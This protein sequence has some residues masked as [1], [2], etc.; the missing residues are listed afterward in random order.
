MVPPIIV[1]RADHLSLGHLA[2]ADH[3]SRVK[4]LRVHM[5]VTKADVLA[6]TV[7]DEVERLVAGRAHQN[8]V[9]DGDDIFLIGLAAVGA[10]AAR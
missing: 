3:A 7:D 1:D 2:P 6:G 4:H 8:A 10:H 9:T 5:Q